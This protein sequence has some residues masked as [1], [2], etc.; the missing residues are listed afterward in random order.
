MWTLPLLAAAIALCF[1]VLLLR[2]YTRRRRPAQLLWAAALLMYA[3]A[4][5][6]LA[7]GVLDGWSVAEYRWYW[8]LGAVLNVPYLAAG[9]LFLLVRERRVRLAALLLLAFGTAFALARVRTGTVDVVALGRELPR[10]SEAW[11]EDPF[12]LDLARYYAFPAYFFLVGGTL[13]SAWRMRGR[14]ELRDRF[15]GTLGIAI[16]ATVIAA[17]SAFALAGQLAGFS[18]TLAVGVAAMFWGFLRGG[19]RAERSG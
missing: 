7:L 15:L 6:A 10:G 1:A 9:E 12:V 19:G 14:P 13:W 17:G 4:S 18:A 2:A 8:A 16:G 5:F 3:G 11:A